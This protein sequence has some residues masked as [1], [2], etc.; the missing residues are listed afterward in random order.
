MMNGATLL[1]NLLVARRYEEEGFTHVSDPVATYEQRYA[2]WLER[3][4]SLAT[5]LRAW[6]VDDLW[7]ATAGAVATH[8]TRNFIQF[9]TAAVKN[10]AVQH[11]LSDDGTELLRRVTE[12]E[13][14][15]KRTQARLTNTK[16]LGAWSGASGVGELAFRCR[17]SVGSE[18]LESMRLH[19]SAPEWTSPAAPNCCGAGGW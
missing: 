18:A 17:R 16:L 9:W 1:Y 10:D 5:Q 4:D 6:S 19:L 8:R 13:R 15:L 2:R 12:W 7:A 3:I 11:A 14:E